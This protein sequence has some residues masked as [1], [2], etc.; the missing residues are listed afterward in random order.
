[1]TRMTHSYTPL[2]ALLGLVA[3]GGSDAPEAA[4]EQAPAESPAPAQAEP[5]MTVMITAPAQDS[6][7]D[8]G[9][10]LV[11][12]EVQGFTVVPAGDQT[13][14]SGHHHLIVNADLP[15]MDAPIPVV[16]GQYIHMGAGQTE[17]A[18]TDLAPGEYTVI[19]LVGDFAHVPLDPP[20]A[21]TVHFVV[22]E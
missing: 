19:A 15:P 2:F 4:P 17:L 18:L 5:P 22:R 7:V 1:M 14:R 20:V 21:D 3:C 6:E 10:V 13:P 12:L 11:T 16:E 8:G 9:S